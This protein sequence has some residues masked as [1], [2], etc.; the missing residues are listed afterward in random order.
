MRVA[1]LAHLPP[2]PATSGGQ[3][4]S[5]Q[6]LEALC[7]CA[8]VDLYTIARSDADEE[9]LRGPL[10]A[11]FNGTLKTFRIGRGPGQD[12]IA[13]LRSRYLLTPWFV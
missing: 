8:A 9:N 1:F 11:W 4:K 6:T 7:R 10:P 5:I 2:W 12:V 13:W 3:Q